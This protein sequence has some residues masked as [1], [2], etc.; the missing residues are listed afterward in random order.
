VTQTS[1][2]PREVVNETLS[3]SA[4]AMILAHNHPSGVLDPSRADGYLT[5][6]L[7][8]A[9]PRVDLRTLDHLVVAG[10]DVCSLAER[11]RI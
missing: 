9:L 1:V 6:T 11:G 4:A 8:A 2:H 7:E 5:Q 3:P 10:T